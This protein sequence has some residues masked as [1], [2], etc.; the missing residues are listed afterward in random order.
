MK[1]RFIGSLLL[2]IFSDSVPRLEVQGKKNGPPFQAGRG[3]LDMLLAEVVQHPVAHLPR[4]RHGKFRDGH[5][6]EQRAQPLL[7]LQAQ[8][9][10]LVLPSASDIPHTH[11]PGVSLDEIKRFYADFDEKWPPIRAAIQNFVAYSSVTAAFRAST[12]S[13]FSQETPRSSR[14]MWP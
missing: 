14:P 5:R 9:R 1:Q 2:R 12:R 13:V 4:L 7:R 3:S 8:D 6:V 10:R 11:H